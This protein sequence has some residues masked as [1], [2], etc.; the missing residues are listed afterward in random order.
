MIKKIRLMLEYNTYCIWLYNEKMKLLT[1]TI[2]RSG[3]TTRS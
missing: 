2:L 3:V 1:M